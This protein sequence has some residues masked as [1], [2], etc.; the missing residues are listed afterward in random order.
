ME[1]VKLT[2]QQ[3][4][5]VKNLPSQTS[6]GREALVESHFKQTFQNNWAFL[7]DL[8]TDDFIKCFYVPDG[9]E[10]ELTEQ[11]QINKL[12]EDNGV[13]S[14]VLSHY[15]NGI[16]DTLIALNRQDLIPKGKS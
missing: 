13:S 1:K 2:K 5:I 16:T 9:Y 3:A 12:W 11:E 8:S 14:V 10:I 4:N 7:N 6:C 15:L